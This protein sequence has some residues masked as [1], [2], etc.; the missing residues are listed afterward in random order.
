MIINNNENQIEVIGDIQEFKTGI[1]PKNLE[2]ITT[3]LSSNLYSAPERSF[4][5]EIVSNAWDSH[6]EAGTTETPVLIRM[7]EGYITIRDFGT[8]LSPERFK[9]VY[10]NIGSSTKRDSN[11]YIG[12]FGIGK[13]SSLAV[14]DTVEITSYYEGKAYY[15]IML[16]EGNH[17]TNN[18]VLVTDTQEKNGVEVTVRNIKNMDKYIEALSY[19]TF[20][21]NVYV[22]SPIYGAANINSIKI[23]N[24]KTFSCASSKTYYKLLLGNVLYPLDCSSVNLPEEDYKF[25]R[26]IDNTGIVIK[27][28]IGEIEVTPNR[29]SV[30]YSEKTINLIKER[31]AEAKKEIYSY[32]IKY[33]TKDY[34]DL[35][36]LDR[37]V[38]GSKR[39]NFITLEEDDRY[40]SLMYYP[41]ELDEGLMTY[42][43]RKLSKEDLSN[44]HT[45][46]QLYSPWARAFVEDRI[47][48]DMNKLP[49]RLKLYTS[50]KNTKVLIIPP[51]QRLSSNIKLFLKDTYYNYVVYNEFTLKEFTE[52]VYDV[53]KPTMPIWNDEFALIVQDLYN[54]INS[55]AVHIDFNTNTQY[56]KF[57]ELYKSTTKL[58]LIK[59]VRL[60]IRNYRYDY[61]NKYTNVFTTLEEAVNYIKK[62]KCGVVL[63][64]IGPTNELLSST[65]CPR[66][67]YYITASIPII[68][69]L[70]KLSF[71]NIVDKDKVLNHDR[72]ITELAC[73]M[74]YKLDRHISAS[75]L[76]TIPEDFQNIIGQINDIQVRYKRL[77]PYATTLKD[78]VDNS[79][80]RSIADKIDYYIK[81]YNQILSTFCIDYVTNKDIVTALLIKTKSYRVSKEAYNSYRNNKILKFLKDGKSN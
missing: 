61:V 63:D 10:C 19:I 42:K 78:K 75:I 13:F 2:L 54:Y 31:I 60:Y 77:I 16:K 62:L 34:D 14:S 68:E 67:F 28:N 27:F 24:Y 66:G 7:K 72:I 22:D 35:L 48:T 45:L 79:Y 73:I 52:F 6:V 8:G 46:L 58:P 15:Y 4:I 38:S 32:I 25:I 65:I 41:T 51:T 81:A 5:R 12:G 53:F 64:N 57:K 40:T 74:K 11:D 37:S 56:L 18:L 76:F 55:N 26:K 43:G 69:E 36:S 17:I 59:N 47:Y 80:Y 39:F 70:K 44:I 33:N 1:D 9:D 21:P 23:K 71:S 49:Y 29:E 50:F 30:I 20:F 3:L